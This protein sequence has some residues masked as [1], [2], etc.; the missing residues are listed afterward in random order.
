MEY[1]NIQ[2]HGAVDG[3]TGSCHRLCVSEQQHILIDCGLFQGAETSGKANQLIPEIDFPTEHIKGLIVTHCHI[4]HVGRIPWLIAAGFT[5]PIYCTPA[6]AQL[7]PLVLEDAI[8]IGITKK[9]PFIEALLKRIKSQINAKPYKRWFN[10]SGVQN[11]KIKFQPAGHILGSAYVEIEH[12]PTAHK[13]VFSGDLGAPHTPL[14]PAPRSPYRADTLVIESTYGDKKHTGRRQR[15]KQLQ[16]VIEKCLQDRGAVLIPAFSIGRTQELLYE[17]EDII[18]RSKNNGLTNRNIWH[19]MQVILDSPLAA[20]FTE[21][22]KS[23]SKLWDAEA[24]Q[25]IVRHRHPLDFD[26]LYTIDSHEEHLNAINYIQKTATPCIIIAAS[27]MCSG[28]RICNYLKAL[29]PDKRTD[30]LFVGYQA[31]GTPGRDIQKYGPKGGYVVIDG[32]KI[33]IKAG[34]HTLSGYSAHADQKDLL[35]FVKRMRIKPKHIKIVHGD[36]D[37]KLALKKEYER[38]LP[39]AKI[40]I[41]SSE[42]GS[43][44]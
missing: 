25:K 42:S 21:H 39:E 14:L 40:E 16:Q 7:L 34:V 4:D 30:V 31:K 8:K 38:I 10:A 15:R 26:D 41:A 3:V 27:G 2:H 32:E 29:L 20:K 6:T 43:S 22:Y 11:V 44:L 37:A 13:Y 9:K 24:Q 28:G 33:D 36:D 23:L 1:P 12:Q 5:G 18:S 35:N 17:I 19:S